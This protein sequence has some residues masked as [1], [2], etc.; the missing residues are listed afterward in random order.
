[1]GE[2]R[3]IIPKRCTKKLIIMRILDQDTDKALENVMI[4]L[5]KDEAEELYEELGRLLKSSKID[6][7][8]HI[9]DSDCEREITVSIYEKEKLDG[10]HDRIKKLI[11]MG[12]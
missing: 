8:G 5:E 3:S 1:M 11:I 7:H 10:F 6:D 2:E 9:E 4:L 12:V